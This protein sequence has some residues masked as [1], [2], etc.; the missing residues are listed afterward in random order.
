MASGEAFE[1]PAESANPVRLVKC[2]REKCNAWNLTQKTSWK[3]T[4]CS[5]Q[6]AASKSFVCGAFPIAQIEMIQAAF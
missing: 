5:K 1:F 3:S 2:I 4:Q 6:V